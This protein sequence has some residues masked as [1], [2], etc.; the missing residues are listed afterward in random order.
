MKVATG[1]F[2]DDCDWESICHIFAN[3]SRPQLIIEDEEYKA[4]TDKIDP[5]CAPIDDTALREY[6]L[7]IFSIPSTDPE[8]K[9]SLLKKLT[10]L[11]E[12]SWPLKTV[13]GLTLTVEPRDI[14]NSMVKCK[15]HIDNVTWKCTKHS[16]Q[17]LR[18]C[19]D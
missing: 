18:S 16:V 6:M 12:S 7:Q 15:L 11:T 5:S 14:M 17:I 1:E 8:A 4:L 9:I 19:N 10:Q 2:I 13:S 3:P